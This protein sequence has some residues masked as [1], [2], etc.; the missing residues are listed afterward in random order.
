[1]GTLFLITQLVVS[2]MGN[3]PW[4][5]Y[6]LASSKAEIPGPVLK[7]LSDRLCHGCEIADFG[8]PWNSTDAVYENLPFLRLV[9]A[10]HSETEWL[11]EY[12]QGGLA[13][14]FHSIVLPLNP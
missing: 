5:G 10:G 13:H 7:A 3:E 4:N 12:E 8:G 14:T 1:M 9:K 6:S 11:I 2:T